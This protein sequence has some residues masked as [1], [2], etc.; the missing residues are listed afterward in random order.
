MVVHGVSKIDSKPLLL[1]TKTN[2]NNAIEASK[3]AGRQKITSAGKLANFSVRI[4][5]NCVVKGG[6]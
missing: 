1:T 3:A 6:K 5:A 4:C 2:A